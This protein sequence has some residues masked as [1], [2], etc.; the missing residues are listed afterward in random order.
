MTT[1]PETS[2]P[3]QESIGR[4]LQRLKIERAS[5]THTVNGYQRDLG[6]LVQW[7]G[8]QGI[9]DW[10]TLRG[11]HLRQ[12]LAAQHRAGLAAK[13]VQRL[14]SACRG[15][16]RELQRNSLITLDPSTGVRGPKATR[17]LPQVLD[18]DEM[19]ALV[20]L[21][22]DNKMGRRDRAMLELFYSSGL[23]LSELIGLRWADLDLQEGM[24]RVLGKGGKTRIVPVGRAATEAL[25]A[26]RDADINDAK[27]VF[28]NP[29]GEPL[30]AR[31]VQQRVRGAA[32]QQGIWKRV[33]PH[34]LRHSCASHVLESS[35]DL[36]AVQEL[37]GHADIAT[38]QIYTHLDFQH[39]ARVYDAA[40]PRAKRRS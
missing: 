24:V 22:S 25:L 19:Q 35:S 38:T 12:F 28:C 20:T 10:S 27:P 15:L 7:C 6:K 8:D 14:L 34:L 1:A 11:E 2:N 37:L 9:T 13:S 32:Q 39:L 4:Y 29:R 3:L 21:P 36:R 18:V 33:H 16:F 5:S 30:S 23:R 17:K 31:A 26:H 40:H